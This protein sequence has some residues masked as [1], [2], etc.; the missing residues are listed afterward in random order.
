M[1]VD[2]KY[3]ELREEKIMQDGHFISPK[4]KLLYIC[5]EED[6]IQFETVDDTDIKRIFWAGLY[7][8]DFLYET[9]EDW[10]I[11]KIKQREK[12]ITGQWL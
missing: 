12:E 11:E 1:I 10:S 9:Q 8:V 6:M 2:C 7:E 5:T 4:Q 3:F